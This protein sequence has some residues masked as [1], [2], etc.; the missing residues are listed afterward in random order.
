MEDRL[1]LHRLV[2]DLPE[3][4]LPA[5]RCFLGYLRREAED[6]F[7]SFLDAAPVDDEPVTKA[8][9][10]AIREGLL[11]RARGEVISHEDVKRRVGEG[12]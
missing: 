8:D 10:A 7:R 6:V 3:S 12:G 4:E 9:L 5:A 11:E 2:D 1:A